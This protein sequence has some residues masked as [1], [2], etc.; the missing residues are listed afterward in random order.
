MASRKE[1]L[2]AYTFARKRVVAA[3]LQPSPAGSDE[4]APGR[5]AP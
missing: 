4:G 3:F 1:Q 5:C 2:N